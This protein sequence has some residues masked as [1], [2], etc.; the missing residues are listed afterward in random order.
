MPNISHKSNSLHFYILICWFNLKGSIG[1]SALHTQ[2][3]FKHDRYNRIQDR[4]CVY[5]EFS[6]AY[7]KYLLSMVLG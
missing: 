5:M 4:L 2:K 3:L 1:I 6:H 7:S